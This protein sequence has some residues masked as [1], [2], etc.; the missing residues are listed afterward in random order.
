MFLKIVIMGSQQKVFKLHN[1]SK[2]ETRHRRS[3]MANGSLPVSSPV[4]GTIA[5]I[6]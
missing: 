1:S 6:D 5:N 4:A 2:R 3:E